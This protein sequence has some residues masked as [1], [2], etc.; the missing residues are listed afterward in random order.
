MQH[1]LARASVCAVFLVGTSLFV[2]PSKAKANPLLSV[3]A[4][5]GWEIETSDDVISTATTFYGDKYVHLGPYV[6]S[7]TV[8]G[9][10]A[11]FALPNGINDMWVDVPAFMDWNAPTLEFAATH[12][13]GAGENFYFGVSRLSTLV[14]ITSAVDVTRAISDPVFTQDVVTRTVTATLNVPGS[15]LSGYDILHVDLSEWNQAEGIS[16]TVTDA[17]IPGA[18]W[19]GNGSYAADANGLSGAY[20]FVMEV[21]FTR[22][23]PVAQT[24]IG[25]LYYKPGIAVSY[26]NQTGWSNSTGSTVSQDFGGGLVTTV[27]TAGVVDFSIQKNSNV[28]EL[29]MN[30][31]AAANNSAAAP[32]EIVLVRLQRRTLSG[33]M[34][35]EFFVE[36]DGNNLVGGSVTTPGAGGNTYKMVGYDEGWE[37][38]CESTNAGDLA[39]FTAGEYIIKIEGADGNE[40]TYKVTLAGDFPNEFPVLD[41]PMGFETTEPRPTLSWNDPNDPDVNFALFEMEMGGYDEDIDLIPGTDPMS[42]TPSEDLDLGGAFMWVVFGDIVSGTVS[43]EEAGGPTGV[44]FLSGFATST[45]SYMNVVPEPASAGLLAAGACLLLRRR[46]RRRAYA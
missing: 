7:G 12:S 45:D 27:S 36:V 35:H 11:A 13:L 41:Q 26:M 14:P 8:S 42:F 16:M 32:G 43:A 15:A 21:Q 23:G 33:H 24:Q 44:E 38:W 6:D 39:E 20:E 25:D 18:F 2:G 5:E 9:L 22:S 4:A 28:T 40:Q 17:N 34:V 37:F 46:R 3:W 10:T 19:G 30:P 31:I 29:R 1:L